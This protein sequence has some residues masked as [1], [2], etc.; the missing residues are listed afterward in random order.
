[1][2]MKTWFKSGSPWIWM[3]AGGVSLSLI[4][5]IGLLWLIAAN[6]LSYFWPSDIHQFELQDSQGNKQTVIGEIYDR[7]KIPRTQL[8]AQLNLPGDSE[9]IERLLV[10]T[11][12]RELV[13]L[14]FRWILVPQIA[15]QST[16]EDIAV[17]ERRT[18]GNFTA[19]SRHCI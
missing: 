16:P 14:D 10:K 1:M 15:A 19:E 12:N 17:I 3:S 11:G 8:S 6:G 7:E 2:S 13:S 5:V 9:T 4:S 18:N